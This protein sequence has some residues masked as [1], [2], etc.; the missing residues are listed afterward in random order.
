[1]KL[2]LAGLE[3]FRYKLQ[4]KSQIFEHGR[5]SKTFVTF[6]LSVVKTSNLKF[7]RWQ[8]KSQNRVEPRLHLFEQAR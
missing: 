2:H 8:A 1:M 6:K 3:T 5:D 4:I 7:W